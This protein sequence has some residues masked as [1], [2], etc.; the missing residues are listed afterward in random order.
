MPQ[1]LFINPASLDQNELLKRMI[2]PPPLISNSNARYLKRLLREGEI[3]YSRI[4][5]KEL[6]DESTLEEVDWAK[7][8]F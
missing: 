2:L 4:P 3:F 8:G 5:I 1:K 7:E 6:I